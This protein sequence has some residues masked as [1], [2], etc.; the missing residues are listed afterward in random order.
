MTPEQRDLALGLVIVPGR[1]LP[2]K[3][4]FLAAWGTRDGSQLGVEQLEGAT[5]REDGTDVE[6]AL[7]I[8]FSFGLRP[9]LL[10][11]LT[12]LTDASFHQAHENI[13][14]AL[15]DLRDP[16]SI[17]AL[18]RLAAT[19]PDYLAWDENRAL[20]RKAIFGLG[21]LQTAQADAALD[22]LAR[23]ADP[24]LVAF[25]AEQRQR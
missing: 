1:P 17:P 5:D 25:V 8:C 9:E 22:Q 6:F 13:A 18:L 20:A 21:N 16:R 19:V 15:D 4:A 10:P 11:T 24:Q 7:V 23:T 14:S 3:D 12:R 2:D